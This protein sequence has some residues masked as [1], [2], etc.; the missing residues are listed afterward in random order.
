[1]LCIKN[2]LK[3]N[4]FLYNLNSVYLGHEQFKI[5]FLKKLGKN[6]YKFFF[7]I[8]FKNYTSKQ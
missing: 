7:L 3:I 4:Q 2:I 5:N 1:M 6:S 8:L